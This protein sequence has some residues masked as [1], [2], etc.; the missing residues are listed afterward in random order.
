[1]YKLRAYQQDAV[2]AVISHF[3]RSKDPALVVL[4]TGAGKSLV[5]AELARKA[6][7]NVLVL[8][9][10][11]ELV[12]QNHEKYE[13]YGEK[14]GIYSASLQRKESTHKVTFGGIQSVARAPDRFFKSIS[15]L[16]I[17][18]CHRI[19]A[20]ENSQYAQVIAKLRNVNPEI[21]ILGLTA[22]PYRLGMGWIFEYHYRG[23]LAA[24]E[25]R[26]FKKCIFELP[27]EY[28]IDNGYLT[29]P[30]MIDAPVACY[31]FSSLQPA[32]TTGTFSPQEIQK[33]LTDQK[34]VTPG[35]I[36]HIVKMSDDRQG[37]M[38]FT[39]T[40]EHAQEILA[41][42]P[43]DSSRLVIGSTSTEERNDTITAF[44]N[45][46]IKFLVNV[47]VLTT[48]FDAPHVD[49]IALL[50]PTESVGL[51]QQIVG[52][53]LRLSPGKT[54]CLIL[55]YTGSPHD[56]FSPEIGS[57]KPSEDAEM[58]YVPCPECDFENLFWGIVD[59]E[60]NV[61]DH[62]GRKCKGAIEDPQTLQVNPCSFRFRF[63]ICDECGAENDIA[64]RSC[65]TCR[66]LIV[67]IDDRLRKAMELRD[68]HVMRPDTM[69]MEKTI[70]KKKRERLEISYYDVDGERLREFFYFETPAQ[71]RAF[72]YNY[73][74]MHLR[75]PGT[76]TQISNIDDVIK[77]QNLFKAPA[78]II[79]RK[80]THFWQ[81]R[82]KIFTN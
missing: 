52:R 32:N 23:Y 35:I 49:L 50:R 77:N 25:P 13:S 17:D 82:E 44:K 10:V 6:Q 51:F 68:A 47:S 26:F 33:I 80:K 76:T 28:M 19:S 2:D 9:H 79:A 24:A 62:F 66:H 42:L 41:L 4:P 21:C 71:V 11:K 7:G 18:E 59:D 64:A 73:T 38:I 53:G 22:T 36:G 20:D 54:D 63:K 45:R 14:A 57:K 16:I 55:D 81:I 67:D 75:L 29:P 27:L 12:E 5:I 34:R 56:V 70:D 48:G 37:V 43:A 1:M 39:S 60:G 8:A 58:V 46:E 74:R 40:I 15:I 30:V 65:N 78:F 31:D 69:L 3:R 61:T 72:Y